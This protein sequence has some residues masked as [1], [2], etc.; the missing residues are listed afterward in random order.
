ML[1]KINRHES[2]NFDF[3]EN[4]MKASSDFMQI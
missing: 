3:D 1:L 2:N 4:F